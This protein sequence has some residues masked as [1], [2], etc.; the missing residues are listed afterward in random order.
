MVLSVLIVFFFKKDLRM[1]E[2]FVKYEKFFKFV[3]SEDVFNE[4]GKKYFFIF[5]VF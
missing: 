5:F 2:E 3:Y 1:K 4:K